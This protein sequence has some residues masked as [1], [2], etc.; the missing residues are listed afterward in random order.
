[1]LS[2]VLCLFGLIGGAAHGVFEALASAAAGLIAGLWIA[3]RDRA[4]EQTLQQK[5][6]ELEDKSRWLYDALGAL[7]RER[8]ASQLQSEVEAVPTPTPATTLAEFPATGTEPDRAPVTASVSAQA[9]P[10][11]ALH[12]PGTRTQTAPTRA[13]PHS[14]AAAVDAP[15]AWAALWS[16]LMG[17]NPL[18]RIGVIVLFFGVASALRLAAQAGIL[19]PGFRLAAAVAAG[20]VMIVAGWR[21]KGA[22]QRRMFALAVQGGGFA[23]LYLAVY[24]ALSAY[25]FITAG[26]AFGLFAALGVACALMAARQSA[27]I[28]ALLGLSGAFVAPMLASTGQGDH[29]VLFSYYL[30]LDAFIIALSWRHAW[31]ALIFAGFAFTFVIGTGWG[32]RSYTPDD[33]IAVQCFLIAFFVLYSATHVALTVARA[34]GAAGWESGSLLFGPP[35]AAGVL[36]AALMQP[37]EYGDAI[38]SAIAG[39]YYLALALLLR[40]RA[41]DALP[42]FRAYAGIG[43]ALLTLAVPLALDLQM[44]AAVYAVEG[45]AAL[46]YGCV[47]ASKLTL[48]AGAALQGLAGLWLVAALPDISTAWP[49]ANGRTLGCLLLAGAALASVRVLR[50][51]GATSNG[52][53]NVLTAWLAAWWM[54]GGLADIDDFAPHDLQPALVLLFGIASAAFA[55]QQ[56]RMRDFVTARAL[57]ALSLP[58]LWAGSLAAW[59]MQQHLLSGAMALAL[60]LAWA[61][62]VW[63]LRRHDED[64]VALANRA[65]HVLMAWTLMLSV[66]I[67]AGSWLNTW[68]P[69]Q[70]LWPWLSWIAVWLFAG[71][72]LQR[73]LAADPQTWPWAMHRDAYARLVLWPVACLLLLTVA[74]LQTAHDGGS[75]LRYLPLVSALDL[76][77]V[78]ALLWLV[79]VA[80]NGLLPMPLIGAAGLLWVSALAARGVHHLADVAWSGSAM[81]QSTLLQAVLSLTW[82]LA[83]LALMIHATRSGART[84]W[85]AGFALLAAVGAKMLMVDLARAGTVEWTASL[86]GIG[87]LILIASYVAPVP[88]ATDPEG[89]ST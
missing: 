77:S 13:Q 46:W 37:F 24:F 22:G 19:P 32:L 41:P 89:V 67:E 5:L 3:S 84:V 45:A 42:T 1:M 43:A 29:I 61:T 66:G 14:A 4:R 27:Q 2:A 53:P 79:S 20:L 6:R 12:A 9:A 18:A 57:A 7:Q 81:F 68:L 74:A 39:L 63:I 88:P 16:R 34:P 72:T 51:S 75:T 52:L 55:E 15:P 82:T 65:R 86:L 38:S 83:A 33:Y 47:R 21:M 60:P 54:F 56:G 76:V 28:L 48:W 87:A 49:L 78:A 85:F 59:D 31:R 40:T 58:V 73:A 70:D 10:L 8:S 80:K 23:L 36:Q 30:L 64:G 17:S 62:H 71:R 11:D 26:P 44:T 69:A 25:G 35:L 50:H